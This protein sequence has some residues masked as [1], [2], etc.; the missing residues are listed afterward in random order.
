MANPDSLTT[1]PETQHLKRLRHWGSR[2]IQTLGGET[3]AE[4]VVD[5]ITTLDGYASGDGWPG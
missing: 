2:T 3:M 5:F 4:L 1:A